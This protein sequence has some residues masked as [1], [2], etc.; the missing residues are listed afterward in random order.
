[1]NKSL[2]KNYFDTSKSTKSAK[3]PLYKKQINSNLSSQSFSINKK[4]QNYT[5]KFRINCSTGKKLKEENQNYKNLNSESEEELSIIQSLWDDLGVNIYYQ[6]DFKK[7]INELK[8]DTQKNDILNHEKNHLT[9]FREALL[10]LSNE[11]SNRDYYIL[12]IKK[13]CK[14]L[15]KY[16][17]DKNAE[18]LPENLFEDIQKSIK[19]YRIN[20]I[21]VINKVMKLREVSSYYELIKKWNPSYANKTY[22]Y[23]KNY[24][25]TMFNDIRFIN[26]S[27]LFN[28]METDNGIKKTDLFF[29]NCTKL[30]TN[31]GKDLKLTLSIDLQ[32]AINKCKYIILQDRI[33]SNIKAEKNLFS[34][35]NI[36]SYRSFRMPNLKT[37]KTQSEVS[38]INDKNEKKYVEMFGHNKINLSRTLYYLKR[39][40]GN[41]YEKMFINNSNQKKNSKKDNLDIMNKYFS[42]GN[43]KNK[44]SEKIC[45]NNEDI[46]IQ[47]S[48]VKSNTNLKEN[49]L[50]KPVI[51]SLENV[52]EPTEIKNINVNN[53]T[54]DEKNNVGSNRESTIIK[55]DN[56]NNIEVHINEKEKEND[57][58]IENTNKNNDINNKVNDDIKSIK[59]IEN[60]N[61]HN[62]KEN[63]KEKEKLGN[64]NEPINN[65]KVKEIKEINSDYKIK[66]V[67]ESIENL[68]KLREKGKESQKNEE[69]KEKEIEKETVEE[70]EKIEEK[71]KKKEGEKEK[72]KE[73]EE[74]KEDLKINEI[75]E[76][77][78]KIIEKE[79]IEEKKSEKEYNKEEKGEIQEVSAEDK[80]DKKSEKEENKN[81]NIYNNF[82]EK[83]DNVPKKKL[84]KYRQYT[85]EEMKKL[86]NADSEDDFID[87]DYNNI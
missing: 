56:N 66:N 5:E 72:E 34:Q 86:N 73:K 79:N 51:K 23:N 46:N 41:D 19:F 17:L 62:V 29:S 49:D 11:I 25:L 45:N 2:K 24:L 1:M 81:N 50:S 76:P 4:T 10:K 80:K 67:N 26:S 75:I 20:T 38:L 71:E 39:T 53:E 68:D 87:I 27:I 8:S 37:K 21:N 74:G 7:Y 31:E 58:S 83:E 6:E 63:K 28:Y 54:N 70:K 18:E 14:E 47:S 64:N 85:E 3:S 57:K 12:K 78:K 69:E 48:D 42:F 52:K 13:Y 36:F 9:K 65:N 43:N 22:L 15:D 55:A 35:K 16:S 61:I 30:I 44:E 60:E 40:M 84:I 59:K 33:L 32:N 77:V 82:E